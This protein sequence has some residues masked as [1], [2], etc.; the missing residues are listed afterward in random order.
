[1]IED[2]IA[3]EAE[4]SEQDK[5]APIRAGST[6]SRGHARTRTLQVRMNAEE[7]QA[8][9]DMAHASGVPASTLAR[10]LLLG[11]LAGQPDTPRTVL[12]RMRADL[13]ALA[14]TVA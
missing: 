2:L 5:D 6:V 7:L 3:Q 4:A 10:D 12:A 8:L 1:M 9:T 14:A 11:H 13:D